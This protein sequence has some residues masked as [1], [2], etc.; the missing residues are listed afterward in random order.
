MLRHQQAFV[1]AVFTMLLADVVDLAR[2]PSV[3][4][5]SGSRNE[6]LAWVL[7]YMAVAVAMQS[8]IQASQRRADSMITRRRK[9]IAVFVATALILLICPEYG[10]QHTSETAHILTVAVGVLVVLIPIRV[11]LPVL[12]PALPLSGRDEDR[13]LI[14][15]NREWAS[16]IVGI[17]MFALAFWSQFHEVSI[18]SLPSR[19][20]TGTVGAVFIIYGFLAEPLGLI[21]DSGDFEKAT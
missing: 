2:H 11:L 5:T 16:V 12:L 1:L 7:V 19:G 9:T 10:I 14:R 4:I 21:H 8:L 13:L 20:I 6:M 3:W 17:A 18:L 15:T